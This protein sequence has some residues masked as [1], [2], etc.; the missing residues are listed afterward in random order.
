VFNKCEQ[1]LTLAKKCI[2]G[3]KMFKLLWK[4]ARI[5]AAGDRAYT[6]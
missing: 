5:L 4:C 1:P 6:K 2:G 3:R